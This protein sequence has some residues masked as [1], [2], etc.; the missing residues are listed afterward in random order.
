[1]ARST[2]SGLSTL[3]AVLVLG[4]VACGSDAGVSTDR[5]DDGSTGITAGPTSEAP[6]SE[7]P[8]TDSPATDSPATDAPITEDPATSGSTPPTST[9]PIAVEEL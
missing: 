8:T 1:M 4:A 3:V 6:T 7:A 9:P 2:R 5:A